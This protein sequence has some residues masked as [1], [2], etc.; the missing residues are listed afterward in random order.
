[1]QQ[2]LP[3]LLRLNAAAGTLEI[4]WA[5]GCSDALTYAVLRARCM[6]SQ[7][8]RIRQGGQQVEVVDGITVV[9]ARPCGSNAV[10]LV[11]SDG[12]DRGIFPFAYLRELAVNAAINR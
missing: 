4:D 7:C 12:H 5:S 8:R 11:F 10:Q 1:M 3:R 9:E 6:C 2:D